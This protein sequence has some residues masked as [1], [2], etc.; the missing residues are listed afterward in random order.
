MGF[1][2]KLSVVPAFRKSEL[3]VIVKKLA[4]VPLRLSVFVPCV[5]SVTVMSATR[6]SATVLAVSERMLTVLVRP[7]AVGAAFGVSLSAMVTVAK[8]GLPTS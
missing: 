8:A 1:V 6:T 7:T 3:P 4:S 5:S 2:A